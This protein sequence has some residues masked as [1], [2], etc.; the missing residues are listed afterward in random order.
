MFAIANRCRVNP[1]YEAMFEELSLHRAHLIEG[2][3]GFLKWELHRPLG[4]GWYASITYWESRAHHEA[5]RRSEAFMTA[6]RDKPPKDMFAVLGV[7]E[8][9]E[10]VQSSY[11]P[12]A[13]LEAWQN[14]LSERSEL[15]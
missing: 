15:A 7:L 12:E 6:H 8:M 10:V 4:D 13:F 3:P 14:V 5:W 9:T 1:E 2:M 11:S